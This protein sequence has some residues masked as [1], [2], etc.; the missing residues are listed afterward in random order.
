MAYGNNQIKSLC[1]R[2]VWGPPIL[3]SLLLEWNNGVCEIPFCM[4]SQV[5]S[6]AFGYFCFVIQCDTRPH[7][8]AAVTTVYFE[9]MSTLLKYLASPTKSTEL[10]AATKDFRTVKCIRQMWTLQRFLSINLTQLPF[11]K[12][13]AVGY[14]PGPPEYTYSPHLLYIRLPSRLLG[15]CIHFSYPHACYMS[16][17]DPRFNQFVLVTLGLDSRGFG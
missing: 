7:G 14:Y 9:V 16:S 13:P 2:R 12:M 8:S 11:R 3:V 1:I 5:W 17:S 4:R 10:R 15:F 6:S